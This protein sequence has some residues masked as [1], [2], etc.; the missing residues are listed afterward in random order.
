MNIDMAKPGE[1][2]P[3]IPAATLVL[4]RERPEGPPELLLVFTLAD[5]K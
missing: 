1:T 2:I 4:F 5:K 3:A